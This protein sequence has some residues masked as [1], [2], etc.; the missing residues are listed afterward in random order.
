MKLGRIFTFSITNLWRNKFLSAATVAIIA[1]ILFTFNI[2]LSI[3]LIA[4]TGLDDLQ[5]KVDIILYLKE[6]AQPIQVAQFVEDL[7]QVESVKEVIYTSKE[8]ALRNLLN[9]YPVA[10]DP[11]GKYGIDNPLPPNINIV[12]KNAE[13][14]TDIFTL[15][16]SNKYR[17]MFLSLEEN[18][19][20]QK[21]VAKLLKLT[22]SSK[23][24]L[25][26]TLIIFIIASIMIV[27]NAITLSIY[28][29]RNELNIMK[30]VGAP[31]GAIRGPFLI[32]GITYGLL[33]F[34][35]SILLLYAFLKATE[36]DL[37]SFTL[38][39]ELFQ[40]VIIE[41]LCCVGIGVVSSMISTERYLA[42]KK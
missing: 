27:S 7:E 40:F 3:H 12:T 9:K 26:S 29:K 21:I 18:S 13:F 16:E 22:R 33:G 2:I 38:N 10:N 34:I 30:L 24:I 19:E 39:V 5:K 32:E 20:N 1:L 8:D 25:I 11:F 23:K 14:H 31:P 35:I 15:A 17:T 42:T 36:L 28:H 4:R 6:G 37:I 41:L